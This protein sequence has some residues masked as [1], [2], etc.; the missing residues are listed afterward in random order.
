SLII[1]VAESQNTF[2][3]HF[4]QGTLY[5]PDN[6]QAIRQNQEVKPGELV[7][8]YYFR[9]LQCLQIPTNRD[10]Q[11][12]ESAGVQFISYI[13][14]GVYL[15]ALPRWFDLNKL[16]SIHVRSILPVEP[17]WKLAASLREEPYGNWAM[18]GNLVDVDIQLYPTLPIREGAARC[19]E[20]GMIVREEGNQNGYIGLRIPKARIMELA[21]LPF[22]RYM[23]L[24][25]RPQ[26]PDD[27]TGRVIHRTA[28]LDSGHPLGNKFN[29]EGVNLLVRDDGR[30][31]PHID[32]KGRLW[33]KTNNEDPVDHADR[34]GGAMGGAGNLNPQYRGMATGANIYCIDYTVG[35]Q[36]E[37]LPLH[38]SDSITITNTS[39]SDDC[40]KGYTLA[41]QTVDQQLFE[42]PT[43][44]HVF[45]AGN[46]GT[47]NCGYGAGSGWGNITGGHK[48]AKNALAVASIDAN[49]ELSYF[50]SRGPAN[51]GRL[52]PD[53]SGL[54]S[55]VNL[56]LSNNDY[57]VSNGTSYSAPAIAG[58]LAQLS[59]AYKTFNNGEQPEA[60]L[61][62]LA[63]L[64]TAT[65][66]GNPG[67]DFKFGWGIVDSWRAMRL[68]KDKRWTGGNVEHQA[69]STQTLAVPAGVRQLRIM[70]YWADPPADENAAKALVNDLDLTITAPNGTLFQPWKP[71]PTPDP[72]ILNAP[73]GAGR[74]SLNNM[75][76]VVINDPPAGNYTIR[77]N[78]HQV[79]MGPQRYL[80][81]WEFLTD[82]IE[83]TYP[84]GGDALVPG[85][86]V[87]LQWDAH[88]ITPGFTLRY[89]T[90]N[91]KTWVPINIV[92]GDKRFYNWTVPDAVNGQVRF[93]I[94]R[95]NQVDTTGYPLT[96]APVP[97]SPRVEKVCPDSMT[98]AWNRINDTLHYDVYLLG[99]KYMEIAGTTADSFLTLPIQNAGDEQ[100]F[101]LRASYPGDL[102]GR[103]SLAVHWPGGLKNCV[104]PDDIA[105]TGLISPP[106]LPVFACGPV[107]DSIAV[108][109][110]N[111]GV[112]PVTGAS[113]YFQLNAEAPVSEPAPDIPPGDTLIYTFKN[114]LVIAQNGPAD[115][116]VWSSY[117]QED[118]PF[119]DTLQISLQAFVQP[120]DTFF[121]QSFK[122]AAFP[123]DGWKLENPDGEITWA[124]TNFDVVGANGQNTRAVF[125]NCYNYHER[126]ALDYLYLPP[127]DLTDLKN[128]GVV[129]DLSHTIY[130]A[131]FSEELRV[132]VF[133]DCDLSAAPTVV[134]VK[135]DPDLTTTPAFPGFFTPD[136][137]EDWRHEGA[138]LKKFE[139]QRVLIRF[140][141][142][143]D[144]GNNLYLN[145]IGIAEFNPPE[146]I[147]QPIPDTICRVPE[148]V[149]FNA[150][151]AGP[152][153]SYAWQ[154][155]PGA[156]PASTASGPGPHIVSYLTPGNKKVRLIVTE[157]GYSD[158]ATVDLQVLG[159]PQAGFTPVIAG[160]AVSF[161]NTSQY[162]T[163]YLWDFGD[164]STSTDINPVHTYTLPGAYTVTLTASNACTNTPS[165]SSQ[166]FSLDFVDTDDLPE[167]SNLVVAPNPTTGDFRV[168]MYAERVTAVQLVLL[169]LTGRRITTA[170]TTAMPGATRVKFE[171]LNLPAG[172]YRLHVQTESGFR[173]FSVAVQ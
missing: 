54:G 71:D 125:L 88:G 79:P 114:K 130:E 107:K 167:L 101:S 36:D 37:T 153:A 5:F 131:A 150:T 92:S 76:Q 80:L 16:E 60:A 58:C 173:V 90:D 68:L 98:L 143:N 135:N 44:M 38:L 140:V 169:D 124:R 133:P 67:P 136:D 120:V 164:N 129:F 41:T 171:N 8:G 52:K 151:L 20:L 61:L 23:E 55:S 34:V 139:G 48:M 35:F 43:L 3:V 116:K 29:G 95:S 157:S 94:L 161:T 146:A 47:E 45:S 118:A 108:Q 105:L 112:N 78:G 113:L 72:A 27:E 59:H 138:S 11:A 145:N 22:V 163:S 64:N 74:D 83:I 126:G 168:D 77:V 21:A 50:S 96:I 104:Q 1:E 39:Y 26:K 40:N 117:T 132:E 97:A 160:A 111:Q 62:K 9:Y 141:S 165:V 119:N 81:G 100:W 162:A 134:W 127:L 110:I 166:A 149:E 159:A 51:D 87:R 103:R 123:P 128:P 66:V 82:E 152:L 13:P 46:S 30:A 84:D 19:R 18:H 122:S 154:F 14:D 69:S 65:D 148:T 53:I 147:I 172:L 6:F 121:T 56:P 57:I 49:L 2:P 102:A 70:L 12:L 142:T 15:V 28:L 144:F 73:A 17:E 99:D 32:F 115:I 155:G 109:L 137:P 85:E 33:N 170:G 89:S 42:H 10:R 93:S 91:A 4:S 156:L 25:P 31:G 86:T 24:A 75:E 158:S 63:V 7:N 106:A